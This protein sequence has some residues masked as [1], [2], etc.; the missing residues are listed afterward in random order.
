MWFSLCRC[1]AIRHQFPCLIS[2]YWCY[3]KGQ[4]IHNAMLMLS[5][6]SLASVHTQYQAILYDTI[7]S[8]VFYIFKKLYKCRALWKVK[9]KLPECHLSGLNNKCVTGPKNNVKG[10]LFSST[11]TA[12]LPSFLQCAMSTLMYSLLSPGMKLKTQ[13]KVPI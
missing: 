12:Y 11:V 5:N 2:F 7:V 9:S 1:E 3:Y 6:L 8:A 13:L 10:L 4:S